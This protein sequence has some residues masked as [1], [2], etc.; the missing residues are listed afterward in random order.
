MVDTKYWWSCGLS[1]RHKTLVL[2]AT[3]GVA[4][5]LVQAAYPSRVFSGAGSN[6]WESL[7]KERRRLSDDDDCNDI[8]LVVVDTSHL[9]TCGCPVREGVCI[10]QDHMGMLVLYILGI[11]YMFVALSVVCEE[12]FV[13]CLDVFTDASDISMDVAGATFMAAGGSMPELFTSFLGAYHQ[14]DVG[15]AT[16]VGSAVFNV[17]FVIGVCAFF[18]KDVLTL[19]WW[20][21]ARDCTCYIA[22]L[23][24]LVIFFV[25]ISPSEIEWWEA[26]FLLLEYAGYCLLMK[27]ND[28]LNAIVERLLA[29][30]VSVHPAP[31]GGSLQAMSPITVITVSEIVVTDTSAS[32]GVAHAGGNLTLDPELDGGAAHGQRAFRAGLAQLLTQRAEISDAAG[33]AVVTQVAGSLRDAFDVFDLDMDGCISL[34]EVQA[35]LQLVGCESDN[36]ST[37]VVMKSI[38]KSESGDISF[39]DFCR[40]Y[41]AAKTRIE[42]EVRRIFDEFDKDGDGAIEDEELSLVLRN[43]GLYAT[44][45]EAGMAISLALTERQREREDSEDI[46][47]SASIRDV[48]DIAAVGDVDSE[49]V[50]REHSSPGPGESL[51]IL[52]DSP[53]SPGLGLQSQC[54]NFEQFKRWYFT[55]LLPNDHGL[56]QQQQHRRTVDEDTEEHDVNSIKESDPGSVSLDWPEEGLQSQFFYILAYPVLAAL[57]VTMPDVRSSRHKGHVMVAVLQFGISLLW[58]ALFALCLVDWATVASN[59]MGIPVPVAGIT[60]LAAGTSVP[61]LLSSY[62]VAKK[63]E[64]DM[65]V[66][67]SIGSNIFDVLVGLPLPWLC[68]SL[69]RGEAIEVRTRSLGLSVLVLIG[70]LVAVI[71]TVRYMAW[72]MT[73]SLGVVMFLLYFVFIAQDLARQMPEDSPLLDWLCF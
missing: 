28:Q 47:T 66:S 42:V 29:R 10:Q 62:V 11:I 69:A 32:S 43:L 60:V 63:G 31:S 73:K 22:A 4:L 44:K 8:E 59:S 14:N 41:L 15:F 16:I 46:S 49:Q 7:T 56:Q 5:H 6:D 45:E 53:M 27:Y 68:F 30:G 70:M 33:V 13:P 20:P 51:D 26:C 19:T 38:R 36:D 34:Q 25:G 23:L 39:E 57:Y 48:D 1:R 2:L 3:S 50:Q 40:W 17:L 65:A 37:S 67:S 24:S 52:V 54:L 18:S 58:I 71:L 9:T 35:M 55:S 72:Q 21:L 64:G 12:Y 61:D